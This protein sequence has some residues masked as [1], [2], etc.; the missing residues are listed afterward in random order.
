MAEERHMT[1]KRVTLSV[2]E[3]R[4]ARQVVRPGLVVEEVEW[5]RRP[6]YGPSISH[7][8]LLIA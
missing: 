5:V 8:L 3:R 7:P 4:E 2:V 6:V 1:D